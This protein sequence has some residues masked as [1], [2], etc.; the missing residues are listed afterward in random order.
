MCNCV[1]GGGD[2]GLTDSHKLSAVGKFHSPLRED[3]EGV[4]RCLDERVQSSEK[5]IT[6]VQLHMRGSGIRL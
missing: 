1:C 3:T 6:L 5:K 2:L 4:L